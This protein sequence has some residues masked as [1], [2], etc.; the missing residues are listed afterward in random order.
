MKI[1]IVAS[2]NNKRFAPFI[3]E[4]AESLRSKG[5]NIDY[6]G[7]EGKGV[8]GYLSNRG[9]FLNKVASF[10]PDIVHAHYGLSGLLAN[11]QRKTPVVTTYHGSDIHSK[12]L[13]LSL[14][15]IVMRLSAYNIFVSQNLLDIAQYK[16]TNAC[17]LSC[18]VDIKIMFPMSKEEARKHLG[19]D[20]NKRYVLF[21][22]S[23]DNA[24]KNAPLA[25]VAVEKIDN[26]ELV[27]LKGF[28]K[29]EVNIAM[30]ACD[31]QL[32]TSLRE[33]GPLVVKE[34]MA[35]N[36]PVV[37]T[38]V[39]DVRHNIEGV[40]GCFLTDYDAQKTANLLEKAMSYDV[41]E[42]RQRIIDLE[43]SLEAVADKLIGIY[44][45]IADCR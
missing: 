15:T 3:I 4:Q 27:E 8:P 19:W 39:G 32:T 11:L 22:S 24:V 43:L 40:E 41:I 14:S 35:C 21:T 33:S 37:S 45:K 2:Y 20:I 16:K 34:A 31:V 12:G 26:C 18:G 17:I 44:S 10:Q 36:R 30:N 23:F 28:T 42:G 9:K 38:D 5:V 1:L 29:E 13:L 6:F 25:K 7:I